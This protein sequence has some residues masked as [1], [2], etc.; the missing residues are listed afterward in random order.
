VYMIEIIIPKESL[1]SNDID[2]TQKWLS[3]FHIIVEK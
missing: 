1:S 2:Y 3:G